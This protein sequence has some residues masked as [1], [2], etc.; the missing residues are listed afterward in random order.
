VLAV[1]ALLECRIDDEGCEEIAEG[2]G[3]NSTLCEL[4]LR[5]NLIGMK[6]ICY[7][8]DSLVGN[9]SMMKIHFEDNAFLEDVE[10][11]DIMLKLA[12]YLERNNYYLH[13]ILM[14]DMSSLIIDSS[15]L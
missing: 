2:I 15:L 3:V 1:V 4:D 7:I 13:N 9:Y 8:L 5:K 12:D 14:R 10:S 11:Q 6:G